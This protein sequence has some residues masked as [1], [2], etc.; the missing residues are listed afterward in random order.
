MFNTNTELVFSCF[1]PHKHLKIMCFFNVLYLFARLHLCSSERHPLPRTHVC[2]RPLDLL[3]L[4]GVWK[5]YQGMHWCLFCISSQEKAENL[6]EISGE[7]TDVFSG[8]SWFHAS[9]R[10]FVVLMLFKVANTVRCQQ[11]PF[12]LMRYVGLN[13]LTVTWR[14]FTENRTICCRSESS[15][16]SVLSVTQ[17]LRPRKT[18]WC[19]IRFLTSIWF[20]S[21]QFNWIISVSLFWQHNH[22]ALLYE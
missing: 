6:K 15:K 10:V 22:G 9:V 5:R 16:Q 12:D 21:T 11:Q 18:Q 3:P 4:Q 13:Y 7:Y 2:L 8:V 14:S 1:F 20:L 17:H 19:K